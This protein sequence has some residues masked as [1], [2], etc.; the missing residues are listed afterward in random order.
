MTIKPNPATPSAPMAAPGQ[1]PRP[2]TATSMMP[3]QAPSTAGEAAPIATP[4]VA[5]RPRR[6]K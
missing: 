5:Q 4:H 3:P 2:M 1:S 6:M